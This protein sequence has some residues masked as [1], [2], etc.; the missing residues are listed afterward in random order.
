MH[1][2]VTPAAPESHVTVVRRSYPNR[3]NLTSNTSA[4]VSNASC[5]SGSRVSKQGSNAR[6]GG[7]TENS[8]YGGLRATP[9][10][11]RDFFVY[12]VNSDNT[13]DVLSGYLRRQYDNVTC[14]CVYAV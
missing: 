9:L 10:P 6:R 12:R 2:D 11:V 14:E 8:T 13:T 1:G 5:E 4:R 3:L 7:I